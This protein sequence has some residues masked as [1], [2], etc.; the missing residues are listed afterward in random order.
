MVCAMVD[1]SETCVDADGASAYVAGAMSAAES[2][3]VERHIDTCPECRQQL[4]ELARS[5]PHLH[6]HASSPPRPQ[7]TDD[8]DSDRL[9][10]GARVGRYVV[11]AILG[12]GGM[13]AVYRAQDPEL[14]R[15]VALKMVR[16]LAE[17]PMLRD[18]LMREAQAMARL[19]HP[20]VVTVYDLVIHEDR[21]FIAM[22]LIE[23]QSLGSWLT[24][25]KRE[26]GRGWRAIL[27]AF[28]DAGRG[29]AAA[30]EAGLVHRDF[31]PDNVLVD[32]DKS[33]ICVTDF[34]LARLDAGPASHR[35][36]R[37]SASRQGG[38]SPL[39]PMTRTGAIMGTPA[40]M[41]PE[42]YVGAPVD[43]RTDQFSF[44]VSLFEALH[45]QP[46]FDGD[47]LESRATAVLTGRMRS[48]PLN[49]D[50][51]RWLTRVLLRAMRVAP[52]ERWPSLDVMLRE[53]TRDPKRA[54]RR[55][56]LVVPTMLC[57]GLT[58]ALVHRQHTAR[59]A[60][61]A[62]PTAE[63]RLAGVWDAERKKAVEHAFLATGKAHAA[64]AWHGTEHAIDAYAD[65]WRSRYAEASRAASP[66]AL[67]LRRKACIEDRL[68]DLRALGDLLSHADAPVVS[69]AVEA[70]QSLP[71]LSRCDDPRQMAARPPLPESPAAMAKVL[72]IRQELSRATIARTAYKNKEQLALADHA[73]EEARA[74]GYRPLEAEALLVKAQAAKLVESHARGEQILRE[75]LSAAEAGGDDRMRAVILLELF[76][77][78]RMQE[79]TDL[80]DMLREQ[81]IAAVER[82]GGD[83]ELEES[84]ALNLGSMAMTRGKPDEAEPQ[85]RKALALAEKTHGKDTLRSA[86][87]SVALAVALGQQGKH[88]EA[89]ALQ[90]H[91]LATLDALGHD[92]PPV[93][94]AE[95]GIGIELFELL[96]FRD[97]ETH[98]R[99]AVAIAEKGF[100]RDTLAYPLDLLGL[101]LSEQGK[102]AEAR[103]LHQRALAL[104]EKFMRKD[105]PDIV[106]SAMGI[107]RAYL[108]MKQPARALP[109]LERAVKIDA[110]GKRTEQAEAR[111]LLAQALR[112]SRGSPRRIREL[113]QRARDTYRAIG[114]GP[115]HD[116]DLAKLDELLQ[117]GR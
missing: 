69:H 55:A 16:G 57:V 79:K 46:P 44:A 101:T 48:V 73:A 49:P 64:E 95:A 112:E 68:L 93:M 47:T 114:H 21:L 116:R 102:F 4:S 83:P 51:P 75:A 54:W 87:Y 86:S 89:L 5:H 42:Q 94:L 105:H 65:G 38:S 109:F 30:H 24:S 108:G 103:A 32:E 76:G 84:L 82:L 63:Q 115:R 72:E 2:E 60:A 117:S 10:E 3:R 6:A 53:L 52:D 43:A 12:E 104:H 29:L 81:A 113:A 78:I 1:F 88:E 25:E 92:T 58:L 50:V 80:A 99:N 96:H 106:D 111:L 13:G 74:L 17:A 27:R 19:A 23:G 41:A 8:D 7:W 98:L 33:R 40:Y 97:A 107:G 34:G 67:E 59:A 91:A 9:T 56:A 70:S 28:V 85:L 14:G 90:E 39:A 22:E 66:S 62:A 61:P 18:R 31:K 45:G 15:P 77:A 100:A 35:P 11:S 110:P 36:G 37:A 71:A 20:N 26:R